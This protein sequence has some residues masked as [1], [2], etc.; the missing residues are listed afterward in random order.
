[1]IGESEFAQWMREGPGLS[2]KTIQN[3]SQAVRKIS[4]DLVKM[5][6]AFSSLNEI[7]ENANLKML[8]GILCY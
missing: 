6:M 1:M 7:T 5:D 3:Y 2:K 4:N 8:K